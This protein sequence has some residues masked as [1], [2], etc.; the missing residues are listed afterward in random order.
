MTSLDIAGKTDPGKVRERN[1]DSTG[2][3]VGA[4]S[5]A[6]AG[7]VM[8]PAISSG[9]AGAGSGAPDFRASMQARRSLAISPPRW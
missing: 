7:M 3:G 5:G 8:E 4:G 1:E 2:S 9:L 6:S